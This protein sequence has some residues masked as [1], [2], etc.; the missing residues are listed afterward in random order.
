MRQDLLKKFLSDKQ[1]VAVVCNQWGDTG[2]GKLVDLLSTWA[3]IIIRGTGGA[4]AGHTIVVKDQKHIFHL[5]PSGIL[6]DIDGKINI[7][8]R[9][10]AFDPQAV[11]DELDILQG[12]GLSVKHL[13]IS[14]QAP[15]M[16]PFHILIDRMGDKVQKIGTTGR[17]IGPL[18]TDYTARHSLFLNDIFNPEIFREKLTKYLEGKKNILAA[19][20]KEAAKEV[21]AH[22]HLGGGIYFHPEDILDIEAIVKKYTGDFA[23]RLKPYIIDLENFVQTALQA[24]KNILLEGAQGTLLSIDFGTTKFQTSSDCTIDG[25]ARGAGLREGDVEHVFGIAKA[26]YMT[27]VGNGPFPTEFGGKPSEEYCAKGITKDQEKTEHTSR[28]VEY[29]AG[30]DQLNLGIAVRLLGDEYGA[31]TG[32]TRRN[33]WLDL[34]ALKYA[35]Q[36]NGPSLTLTKVDVLDTF[37]KIKLAVAYKYAGPDIFYAGQ[38][39]KAGQ[40]IDF[41]PRFSEILYNCEPVYQE[42]DGWQT[43]IS[44]IEDYEALPQAIKTI[45]DFVEQYTGGKIEV[46]SVGPDRE[47]TIFKF[48]RA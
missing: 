26:F 33:G 24:K 28:V 23:T 6:H 48:Y 7:I 4:N 39:L 14:H 19:L 25:L 46:I 32:R 21:L 34:V 1:C 37:V 30:D 44:G 16:L 15:L 9:G 29:L 18:Y 41:F 8:G 38:E 13:K 40:Q 20:D 3:D 43:A 11:I 17:G 36:Y 27:R 2:K 12:A 31:T 47:Q 42:F 22:P 5:L 10:V 45:V 35:M